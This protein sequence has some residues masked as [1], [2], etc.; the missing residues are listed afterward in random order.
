VPRVRIRALLAAVVAARIASAAPPAA[1]D[2]AL[3]QRWCARCHGER[4]DGRGPA[5]VALALNGRSPRDFTAGAFQFVSTPPGSAPAEA[6]LVRTIAKG[7]PGTSM[8]WFEDLL[9]TAEMGRLA[10]VVQSLVT[11]PRPPA[12][13]IDLGTPVPDD[14][15]SRARGALLSLAL[16]CPACHD[17]P[18]RQDVGAADLTRPWA[19]R[20]G[21]EPR[22]VAL[23]VATGLA[24]TAMPAYLDALTPAELW[25]VANYVLGLARAPSLEAAAIARARRPPGLGEP[26]LARGAYVV[27]SG[28]CF[29][30]HVQMKDDGS[31]V[32]DSFGAGGM[33][34]E[35]LHTATVFTRNLTPHPTGLAD[36]TADDLRAALRE[37]RSRDG[38]R[39]NP[40]DMPWTILTQLAD[41]DIDAIH[42]YLQ[43]LPPRANAVPS[44]TG[45]GF[46]NGFVGK[47]RLLATGAHVVAGFHPGNGGT[48]SDDAP[49][50]QNPTD[51]PIVAGAALALIA[52]HA[53]VRR[54]HWLERALVV[55]IA[56]AVV[57]V[58]TWPPLRW[59]PAALVKAEAPFAGLGELIGMPPIRR[60]PPPVAVDDPDLAALAERGRYVAAI[61]TCP[62]CHTAGPSVTR[63]LG[64]FAEMGGGMRVNWQVFGTT[65]SRNLTPHPTT[66][67]GTWS[68][69]HIRRAITSGIA[70][71]GRQ[72]H[73][74]AMPWDHFSN[75]EPEDLE[76][77]VVYL[78]HLP[79]VDSEVPA[80]VPPAP[81]DAAA[82]TFSFG[83]TGTYRR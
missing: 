76:A 8:P 24:G 14:P 59:M 3:Y 16:G 51:D 26:R 32:E 73:W 50:A 75:L 57:V 42:A 45:P 21:A 31:Y 39:L 67:L 6:D 18:A 30:C 68:R 11:I 9:G 36:W 25:D 70:R 52:V 40:L 22:D 66:G 34:V 78:Q 19:F 58:Y 1:E 20:G 2:V 56:T 60:P 72:M 77:L 37:G 38:R 83:Y 55:T 63:P 33:R 74:Q 48:A 69:A 46:W 80:P 41:E 7:V 62:L 12:D 29:L 23:R 28:T 47:A 65:W 4:G 5:A 13:P 64:A 79:P 35:I 10:A 54:R 61:G 53:L 17:E 81:G 71:D 15:D 49:P 43:S 44:P 27:R 82:D